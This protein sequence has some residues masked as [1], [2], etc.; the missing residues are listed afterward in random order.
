MEKLRKIGW[1]LTGRGVPGPDPGAPDTYKGHEIPAYE[2]ER[3]VG[4]VE[5]RAYP[6]TL[7]ART[8]VDG[9][10][11]A[12][13]STGFRRLAGYI[14]GGNSEARQIE[15]TAPVSSLAR[16]IEM[17]APVASQTGS[18]GLMVTFTLPRGMTHDDAPRPKDDRIEIVQSDPERRA[19]LRFSGATGR[20]VMDARAEELRGVLRDENLTWREPVLEMRYDDPMTL[21]WNRRNEVAFALD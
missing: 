7:E 6:S 14:F 3:R 15:M 10:A 21:P 8:V 13:L 20:D 1:F 18:D 5:I 19:V 4:D 11:Q 16:Q 9:D 12:A 2:V 17:T